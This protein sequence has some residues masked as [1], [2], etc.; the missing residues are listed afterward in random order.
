MAPRSNRQHYINNCKKHGLRSLAQ[1]HNLPILIKINHD[2][3]ILVPQ[4]GGGRDELVAA[5]V[6][7]VRHDLAR[8]MLHH[9]RYRRIHVSTVRSAEGG[10]EG[11]R[12]RQTATF[13]T[14]H[15]TCQTLA[16]TSTTCKPYSILK[17]QRYGKKDAKPRF[18][19][20]REDPVCDAEVARPRPAC[21]IRCCEEP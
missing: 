16:T 13:T 15:E 6:A 3:L 21:R 7:S 10:E 19:R 1:A 14:S 18:Y 12:S 11:R 4:G 2:D 17:Q 20:E 8:L 9:K 5:L